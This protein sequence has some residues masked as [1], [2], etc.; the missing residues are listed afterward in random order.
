M[1]ETVRTGSSAAEVRRVVWAS[2][3]GTTVETYDFVLYGSAAALL[4]GRLFFTNLGPSVGLIASFGTFATGFVVRPLGGIIFGALGDRIGRKP[5]L[6]VTMIMMALGCGLVGVLPTHD[7]I[8]AAAAVALVVLRLVQGLA[9]GGEWGSATLMVAEHA[10]PRRRGFYTAVG[11]AGLPSGAVLATLALAA[12]T[13]LPEGQLFSWGWRIP[14][15][16]SFALLLVGVRIRRQVSESPLFVEPEARAA[17]PKPIRELLSRNGG[18]LVRGILVALPA[19][20]ASTLFSGFAVAYAAGAGH[21]RSVVLL[22]VSVG[23]GVSIVTIPLF[24][25]LSDRIGRRLIYTAGAISFAVVVYPF[26]WA[27]SSSSTVL[28]FL[29]FAVGFGVIG[30]VIASVLGAVLTE[31]FPTQARS[32]GVSVAYQC[33]GLIA[34]L[35]PALFSA[36][37]AASGGG[38]NSQWVALIVVSVM[39]LAGLIVW[40]GAENTGRNLSA[41]DEDRRETA[42]DLGPTPAVG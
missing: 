4:F 38:K 27:V 8:G 18:S 7:Q 13:Q 5:V 14:F 40:F 36:V 29:G 22:A 21:S 28:L 20:V 17:R 1:S 33:A 32:T 39:V 35:F 26:F 30:V 2:Y 37:L 12:V 11:Q 15:L 10:D 31:L 41:V 19:P 23:F 9:F 42:P 16:L 3:I 34:G 25:L 24:G 6:L